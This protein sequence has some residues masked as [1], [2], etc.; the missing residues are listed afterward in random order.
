MISAWFKRVKETCQAYGILNKDSYNFNKTRFIMGIAIILKVVTSSN[1]V[2]RAVLVQLGNR[3][4]VTVIEGINAASQAIPPFII[5]V[6]K[7]Y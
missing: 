2:G 5:L 1:I 3:E 7:V 6:G 4:Q